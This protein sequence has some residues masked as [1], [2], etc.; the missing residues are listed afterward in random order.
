MISQRT[1]PRL[2]AHHISCTVLPC[3][4]DSKRAQHIISAVAY[5]WC[6]LIH[7]KQKQRENE[8]IQKEHLSWRISE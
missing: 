3:I 7:Y 1:L 8:V 4:S 5:V 2:K 6:M